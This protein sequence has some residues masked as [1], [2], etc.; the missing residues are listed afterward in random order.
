MR[1]WEKGL[2]M[3]R[4][5]NAQQPNASPDSS[6]AFTWLGLNQQNLVN[7]Y[8]DPDDDED[9]DP[10]NGQ[11]PAAYGTPVLTPGGM[12]RNAS[13]NSLR[14]RSVT[15]DS[16]QSLAGMVRQPPPRFPMSTTAPL[17][18]QTQ[19]TPSM[20]SPGQHNFDSYFSPTGDSPASSRTS[21]ASAVFAASGGYPFP[22]QAGTSQGWEDHNRYTAPAAPRAPSR[23]GP[24]SMNG[25]NPRGPSMPVM[26]NNAQSA[27]QQQRSRSYSTPDIQNQQRRAQGEQPP[28]VPRVPP[29]LHDPNIPRSQTGSP[30]N[31]IPMRSNTQSPSVQRERLTQQG[32]TMSQFPIQPLRQ[33]T[34]GSM[35]SSLTPPAAIQTIPIE[36]RTAIPLGGGVGSDLPIPTQLKVKVNCENGNYVTLVVPFN[37]SYQLLTDRIDA[38]LARFS[39]SSIGRGNLKLRYRDEDND[40]VTIESDD[41]IQIAF[42]EWKEGIRNMYSGGVG[43]IELFCVGDN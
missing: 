17:S 29:H 36:G 35:V 9:D 8:K 14:A 13:N 6:Q 16:S 12:T 19:M 10:Y 30:R 7:P 25:R 28:A 34:P 1:K 37:I 32:G 42:L 3:Q 31:D 39:S 33:N 18:V 15:Q 26:S 23:D 4:K 41:D 43:E 24:Q 27:A 40:F 20:P 2:D 22:S 5:T 11:I 38:K 21:N